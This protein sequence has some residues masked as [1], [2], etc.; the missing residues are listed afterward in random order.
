MIGDM[1]SL[2]S[3]SLGLIMSTVAIISWWLYPFVV[4]GR[5]TCFLM[6]ETIPFVLY[7]T[8]NLIVD[9]KCCSGRQEDKL[10]GNQN[11]K[12][13]VDIARLTCSI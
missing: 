3:G 1:K 7:I 12:H 4:L 6:H 11:L 8:D 9:L 13:Q 10:S 5:G 2:I